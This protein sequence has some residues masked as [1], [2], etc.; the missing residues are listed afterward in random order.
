MRLVNRE[1]ADYYTEQGLRTFDSEIGKVLIDEDC[2][3]YGNNAT[4]SF[5]LVKF[6]GMGSVTLD[7]A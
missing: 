5:D 1:T 6:L 2:L 7:V 4:F 3:P